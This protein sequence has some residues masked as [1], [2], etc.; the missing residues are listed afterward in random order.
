MY[1][2]FIAVAALVLG[3]FVYGKLVEKIFQPDPNRKTPA[4]SV[5]DGVD[6]VEMPT[7]KVFL[8]QLLNIAGVGPIFGPILGALYGPSALLWIVI[9]SIFGGAVHDY[10]SGMLSIRH[11]GESIP[12]VVGN[13]LGNGMKQFM[14]GFSVILLLLVGIV[15]VSAPAQMLSSITPENLTMPVFVAIIFIYYFV[16]TI[17][18]IDKVIGKIYPIF[19]FLLVFMAIGLIVMLIIKG[20]DFYP[21]RTLQNIDPNKLPMWPLMFITIA[22]G[23]ISGFHATQSPM[24]ART[25]ANEKHGRKVFYGSMIMEGLIALIWATLAMSFFHNSAELNQVLSDGGP[26]HIVNTVS[27]SLLGAVGGILAIVGVVFLPV[28]S[29]DTAFRSARLIIADFLGVDQKSYGKRFLIAIPLFVVG[30]IVS[31][32]DFGIIWRY[33][34]WANQ[35]LAAIVLWTAAVYLYQQGKFHWVATIPSLFMTVVVITFL[36]YSEIGFSF[37][38]RTATIIGVSAAIICLVLFFVLQSKKSGKSN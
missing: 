6:F 22:C 36:F 14:R 4:L 2:F 7:W 27:K 38:V 13:N 30:F 8:I 37:P 25:I 19:G 5:N 24:M 9:G 28:S 18:P 34:G 17:L 12:E 15:F 32:T 35:T 3:Y 26:A 20:Y 33:F 16:A 29:G 31:K 1:L 10:F 11:N 21:E 23:A